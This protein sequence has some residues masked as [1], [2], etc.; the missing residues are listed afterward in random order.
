MEE[1]ISVVVD[2]EGVS[3]DSELKE[4]GQSYKRIL[5]LRPLTALFSLLLRLRASFKFT[6]STII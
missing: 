4:A 5:T 2:G 6:F 3:V 1:D